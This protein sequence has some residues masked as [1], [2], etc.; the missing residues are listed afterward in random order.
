MLMLMIA[1]SMRLLYCCAILSR[2]SMLAQ[3]LQITDESQTRA[4][5]AEKE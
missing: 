3:R 4:D 5:I 2:H 1:L